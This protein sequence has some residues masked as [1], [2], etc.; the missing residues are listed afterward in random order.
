[1]TK[2]IRRILKTILDWI[3][4]E[5][6]PSFMIYCGRDI[7][8]KD[9][10]EAGYVTESMLRIFLARQNI[11]Q[12]YTI[13]DARGCW[14][15]VSEDTVVFEVFDES[16]DIIRLFAYEYKRVFKQEAVYIKIS[17]SFTEII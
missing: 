17:N 12:N 5:E 8:K 14:D 15:D 11:L 2:L 3:N 1:M 7:P 13:W 16:I 9:S 10:N 4:Q 6:N